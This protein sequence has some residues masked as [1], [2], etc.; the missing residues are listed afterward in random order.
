MRRVDIYI[1]A[2]IRGPA[3]GTGRVMY[4]MRTK[5]KNGADHESRPSVA[6]SENATEGRL[7]LMA[8]RDALQRL[9][10]ACEVVVHTESAYIASAIS[11]GWM[12]AWDKNGWKTARGRE[13]QDSILWCQ[14]YRILGEEGHLLSAEAGSHE[15]GQW[16]RWKMQ[17]VNAW[18]DVFF[19]VK[20]EPVCFVQ[21]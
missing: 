12:E 10:Y 7:V 3:R 20:E 17:F 19:E 4:L 9:R 13:V 2:D 18:N 11:N 16:M 8:V 14:V 5:R 15:Y 1:A 6:E 21:Y